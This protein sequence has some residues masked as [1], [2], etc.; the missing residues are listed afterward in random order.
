MALL[1]LDLAVMGSNANQIQLGERRGD[2]DDWRASMKMMTMAMER[3]EDTAD[4]PIYTSHPSA[5]HSSLH[6]IWRPVAEEGAG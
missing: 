3:W 2:E 1:F 6:R 5:H 4:V